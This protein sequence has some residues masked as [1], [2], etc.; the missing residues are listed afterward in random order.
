MH[1]VKILGRTNKFLASRLLCVDYDLDHLDR[2][3]GLGTRCKVQHQ[4]ITAAGQPLLVE[5]I[6]GLLAFLSRLHQPGFSQNGKM[7]RDRRLGNVQLL[8]DFVDREPLAADQSHDLLPGLIRQGF[9]KFNRL[10]CN[11]IDR[12]LF[13]IISKFIYMSREEIAD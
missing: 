12:R 1:F 13:D 3:G 5:R 8:D 11:H 6:E 9:G 4:G 10:C 2:P 7:M